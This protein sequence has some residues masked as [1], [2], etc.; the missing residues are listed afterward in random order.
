MVT[1]LDAQEKRGL[2]FCW[3]ASDASE[4]GLGWFW[5][6][7]ACLDYVGFDCSGWLD[8]LGFDWV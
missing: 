5:I 8:L 3:L 2:F 4:R 7:L 1:H 6:W